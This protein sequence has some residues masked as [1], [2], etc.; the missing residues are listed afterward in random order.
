MNIAIIP[1]RGGS[2]RIARKNIRDFCGLPIIA[3]SI[4]IAKESGI[5]SRIVVSTD[6]NEIAS[7][8]EKFGAEIPFMRPSELADDFTGTIPVVAHA[9]SALEAFKANIACIYPTAPLLSQESLKD[10]LA[11][12]ENGALYSFGAVQYDYPP[13]RSFA[14]SGNS[15][16]MLFPNH[17]STRS[18]DLEPIFHDAGQ[19]YFAHARTWMENR[20]IFTPDSRA[21]VLDAMRVQ[22]IDTLSDWEIAE[23]KYKLLKAHE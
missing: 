12:L 17:F 3:H 13:Q 11:L 10:A 22:D 7:V 15:P 20:A 23:M 5:F 16:R 1:A 6:D 8:A 4:V 9:I 14:L 19:F 21:V 2:K 18:Q